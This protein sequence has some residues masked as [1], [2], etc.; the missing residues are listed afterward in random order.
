MQKRRYAL[1]LA[2]LLLLLIGDV[3]FPQVEQGIVNMALLL[4]NMVTGLFLADQKRQ[5]VKGVFYLFIVLTALRLAGELLDHSDLVDRVG[6]LVFALYFLQ[7]AVMVFNDL[8]KS[9][10]FGIQSIYAVF[11]GFILMALSFGYVFMLLN[12]V[13]PGSL[14]GI[15]ASELSAEYH[16]FSFITLLTIGYGDIT[17]STDVAQRIVVFA[18]LVGQ[19]YTVF[20]T[21]FIIGNYMNQSQKVSG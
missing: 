6:E 18:A 16:Y 12:N 15:E 5:W 1:F 4:L 20:V 11:A 17:P 19:F 9:K 13:Y 14:K 3:F 7:L 10:D 2:S 21:A 8:Y